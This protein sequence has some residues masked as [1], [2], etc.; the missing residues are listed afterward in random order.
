MVK[1][2]VQEGRGHDGIT[3]DLT[4]FG[5]AAI[6]SEDHG[7]FFVAGADALEEQIAATRSYR[8]IADLVDDQEGE[9][10]WN[11][12]FSRKLPSRSALASTPTRSASVVK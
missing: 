4:P 5:K 7:A 8:Q 1:K 3:K 9:A 12:I 10:A 2:P 6:R 11:L